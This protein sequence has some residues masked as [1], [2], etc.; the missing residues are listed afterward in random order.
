MSS[1]QPPCLLDQVRE[2][3]RPKHFSLKTDKSYLYYIRDFIPSH[4]KRHPRKMGSDE[5]RA[6]LTLIQLA[7]QL[8]S[9]ANNSI[10]RL[11]ITCNRSNGPCKPPMV[12]ASGKNQYRHHC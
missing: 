2:A 3:I 7:I 11:R 4:N 1:P 5:I 6:Y 8:T 9:I 10:A 12:I